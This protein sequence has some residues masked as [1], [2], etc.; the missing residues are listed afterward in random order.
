MD[1]ISKHRFRQKLLPS[2]SQARN[3]ICYILVVTAALI[4]LNLYTA[5]NSRQILFKAKHA[6]MQ[7][8]ALLISS[9]L[10]G[11]E[12]LSADSVK[13][14]VELLGEGT[15]TRIIVTD[16]QGWCLYDNLSENSVEQT[17]V[18]L[19]EVYTALCGHDVFHG[20][21]REGSS[22]SYCAVPVMYYDTPIGAVYLMDYEQEQ[23]AMIAMMEATTFRISVILEGVVILFSILF[24]L[25]FSRRMQTILQS[26]PRIR[27]GD[28]DYKINLRGH[29]ELAALAG[30]FD[31]LTDKLADAEDSRRRFVSDASHELKTPLASIK[32]LAETILQNDL[33]T[34][35]QREFVSDICSESERLNRMTQ[36]LLTLSKT[37]SLRTEED[38]EVVVLG[39]VV[40]R[41][42][43]MLRPV[44]AER[45][46]TLSCRLSL[47]CSVLATEDDMYQIIFNLVENAIKYNVNGGQVSVNAWMENDDVTLEVE[48]TGVGIPEDAREHIFERFY[49]VDK[50]RSREAGGAGLGLSIVHDMVE[51]NYGTIVV[52]P[53]R[54]CGSRFILVFP[55]FGVEEVAE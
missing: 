31:K 5:N 39:Y 33:D 43:K 44:A 11:M 42:F 47:D 45:D 51:R 22:T 3:A 26:F 12:Y 32:L 8:K 18:M 46:I 6:S 15:A 24:S 38:R 40:E 37:D 1:T 28:Y 7:E 27:E 49:R 35:T 21:Y 30:E 13:Q 34:E 4:F 14:V 48:D 17:L 55:Y 54:I 9:S 50:A 41:V 19:P 25:I 52:E 2:S 16:E 29:D 36:K 20:S 53:G 23:S 10:S